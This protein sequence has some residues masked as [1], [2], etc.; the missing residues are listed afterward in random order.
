MIGGA[1]TNLKG[2]VSGVIWFSRYKEASVVHLMKFCNSAYSGIFCQ[3]YAGLGVG[4]NGV[5]L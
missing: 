2:G 4:A 5:F 3:S 1:G